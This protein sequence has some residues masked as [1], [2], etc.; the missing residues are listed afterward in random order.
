MLD[1]LFVTSNVKA[2]AEDAANVRLPT[3]K[4]RKRQIEG[5]AVDANGKAATTW[6][7]LK[8]AYR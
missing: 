2:T 7:S 4:D 6:G 1:A 3:D 5:L 8:K